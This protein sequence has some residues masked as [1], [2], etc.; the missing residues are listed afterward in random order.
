MNQDTLDFLKRFLAMTYMISM[1]AIGMFFI[2]LAVLE[3]IGYP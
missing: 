2:A 3:F 1:L